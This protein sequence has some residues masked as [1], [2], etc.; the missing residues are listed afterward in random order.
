MLCGF[1]MLIVPATPLVWIVCSFYVSCMFSMVFC[2][3]WSFRYANV[4]APVGSLVS[5]FAAKTSN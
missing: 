3:S 1:V 2:V 4:F 5:R